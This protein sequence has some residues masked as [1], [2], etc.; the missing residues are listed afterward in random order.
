MFS[1]EDQK[2]LQLL[3]QGQMLLRLIGQGKVSGENAKKA[4][5]QVR[6]IIQELK[7]IPAGDAF[8]TNC[9]SLRASG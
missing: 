7:G 2:A 1:P 9:A 4:V 8:A 6:G 5:A 3:D